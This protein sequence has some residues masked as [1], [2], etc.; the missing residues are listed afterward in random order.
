MGFWTP[1][2]DWIYTA[3]SCTLLLAVIVAVLRPDQP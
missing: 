1:H 2:A 3:V